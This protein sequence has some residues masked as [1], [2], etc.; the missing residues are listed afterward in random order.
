MTQRGQ[1][2]RQIA[3]ISSKPKKKF[4]KAECVILWLP[5]FY[6]IFFQVSCIYTYILKGEFT[7]FPSRVFEISLDGRITNPVRAT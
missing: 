2:R 7:N 5:S 4:A 3:K 6:W 1:K